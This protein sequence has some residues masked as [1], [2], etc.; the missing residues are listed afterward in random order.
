M[1][2]EIICKNCGNR[3]KGTYSNQCGEKIYTE[4]D[5]TFRHFLAESGHF[6]MHFDNKIYRSWWLVMTRPG[7]V[8][9]QITHGVRKRYYNPA[10]LFITGW[11]ILKSVL[12]LALHSIIGYVIYRAILFCLVLL[13]I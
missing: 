2:A 4:H 9:G 12:F 5:K 8:S 11:C 10:N 6:L 7:F 3:F 13:F 1:H